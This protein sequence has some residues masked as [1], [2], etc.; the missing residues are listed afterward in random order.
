V[1]QFADNDVEATFIAC[2]REQQLTLRVCSRLAPLALMA[3]LLVAVQ[4]TQAATAV[5][6]ADG[7]EEATMG[8]GGSVTS[9]AL[10]SVAT[11]S[12]VL[13][14]VLSLVTHKVFF[15]RLLFLL[16]NVPMLTMV[17]SAGLLPQGPAS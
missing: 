12:A 9:V 1:Q 14:L 5:A 13:D 3:V 11:V 8:F 6:P 17:T 7:D 4:V 16:H 15:P 10:L 2:L